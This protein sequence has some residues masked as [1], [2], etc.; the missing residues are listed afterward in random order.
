MSCALRSWHLR[1][2]VP[3]VSLKWQFDRVLAR[4]LSYDKGNAKTVGYLKHYGQM[5]CIG[6]VLLLFK[7]SFAETSY[8][9]MYRMK[10]W[11]LIVPSG[12][13]IFA[14][15]ST[16]FYR[17]NLAMQKLVWIRMLRSLLQFWRCTVML[18]SINETIA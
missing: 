17:I 14:C 4:F 5:L 8:L 16:C 2:K 7:L 10:L 11:F 3:T 9:D 18:A 6:S 12:M 13:F 1:S 15:S